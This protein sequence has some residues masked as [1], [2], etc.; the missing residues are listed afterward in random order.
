VW[1]TSDAATFTINVNLDGTADN[2][3]QGCQSVGTL[4][5]YAAQ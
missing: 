5:W 2:P 3:Y 1:A 4:V